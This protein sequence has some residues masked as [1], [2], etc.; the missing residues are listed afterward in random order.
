[1]ARTADVIVRETLGNL[2]IQIIQMAAELEASQEKCLE[3][4]KAL[5]ERIDPTLA[6][7]QPSETH[8]Q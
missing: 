6:I 7:T 8:S 5:D 4:Q 3:L 2:H 1:M